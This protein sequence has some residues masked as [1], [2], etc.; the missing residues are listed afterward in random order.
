MTRQSDQATTQL[1]QLRADIEFARTDGTM[2]LLRELQ[3]NIFKFLRNRDLTKH[4]SLDDLRLL[5]TFLRDPY[6]APRNL[7][8]AA[9]PVAEVNAEGH[10]TD[11]KNPEILEHPG[12]GAENA[13]QNSE[14]TKPPR[15][16]Y[17][18]H[19][20]DTSTGRPRH[21]D[22]N[23]NHQIPNITLDRTPKPDATMSRPPGQKTSEKKPDRKSITPSPAI[24]AGQR[25]HDSAIRSNPGLQTQQEATSSPTQMGPYDPT[26]RGRYS[27]F[28][29]FSH[30][31]GHT[32]RANINDWLSQKG[33]KPK[34]GET[35]TERVENTRTIISN[36][37]TTDVA[38]RY[39]EV[40]I[41]EETAGMFTTTITMGISALDCW[42]YV[43]VESANNYYPAIPRIT[44]RLLG[45]GHVDDAEVGWHSRPQ[46]ID[47]DELDDLYS[48]LRSQNRQLPVFLVA[49]LDDEEQLDEYLENAKVWYRF[50]PGTAVFAL[51]SPSATAELANRLPHVFTP[52]PWAIRTYLP[53][54]DIEDPD[55]SPR[56]RFIGQYRISSEEQ[57]RTRNRLGKI[58]S[59][60]RALV[61]RPPQLSRAQRAIERAKNR[62]LLFDNEEQLNSMRVR[63]TA[64]KEGT[65]RDGA[66]EKYIASPEELENLAVLRDL[67]GVQSVS[68]DL[69]LE[70]ASLY[71]NRTDTKVLDRLDHISEELT[72]YREEAEQLRIS[73]EY[74]LD[75]SQ[76]LEEALELNQSRLKFVQRELSEAGQNELAYSF[77]SEDD[78][79]DEIASFADLEPI[80]EKLGE[81]GLVFTGD[82]DKMLEIDEIDSKG[83]ALKRLIRCLRCLIEYREETLSSRNTS[84]L[85][86]YLQNP[87]GAYAVP[88][89]YFAPKESESSMNKYGDQRRFSVPAEVDPSGE[90]QMEAHFRLARIGMRS[91]RM[92]ILDDLHRT[93][94]IY[95]GYIGDH[96]T[97]V[98]TN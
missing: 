41:V 68:E 28:I 4:V 73:N 70:L 76:K 74:Y 54:L 91:P 57:E 22:P 64:I 96:L 95:I 88:P 75:E 50:L 80:M 67:V 14:E 45:I 18:Q 39:S 11:S 62:K 60:T 81:T 78:A 66:S 17:Y 87:T 20:S 5:R 34:F 40:R 6:A 47:L 52:S 19:P 42:V 37:D 36:T 71:E 3:S 56:H 92:Y 33:H 84:G 32:V 58:A 90:V 43:E 26:A 49:T 69:V 61:P 2:T 8:K 86:I 9:K 25:R 31:K 77:K 53:H 65:F 85:Y 83:Q 48:Y 35:F 38:T 27:T 98:G 24:F 7:R 46:N 63:S 29:K 21:Q 13:L 16:L 89:S 12:H 10:T 93:E 23:I 55:D 72:Q 94:T 82:L 44:R 79:F 59:E 1:R 51:L 30:S 15:I 97:T